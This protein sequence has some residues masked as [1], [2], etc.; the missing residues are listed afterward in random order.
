M[1]SK[2]LIKLYMSALEPIVDI[3]VVYGGGSHILMRGHYPAH[4]AVS[5]ID[6]LNE[7]IL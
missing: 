1:N 4:S 5:E 2:E 3:D 7:L 6:I